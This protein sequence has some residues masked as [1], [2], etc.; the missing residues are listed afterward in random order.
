MAKVSSKERKEKKEIAQRI[1]QFYGINYNE[2]LHE[3]HFNYINDNLAQYV[4]DQEKQHT[5][6]NTDSNKEQDEQHP[7]GSGSDSLDQG[8]SKKF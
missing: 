5:S 1:M 3:Q 4:E 6:N 7:L 2:W 8:S